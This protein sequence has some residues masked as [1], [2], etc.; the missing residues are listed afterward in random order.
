MN[1][2]PTSE[3]IVMLRTMLGKAG[4][5]HY[6]RIKLAQEIISD[7]EWL[8]T[9][10]NGDQI[11]A[12]EAL[13]KNYFGDLC[14]AISFWRLLRIIEE[15]PN[16]KDWKEHKFNLTKMSAII[17]ARNEK[18][19][20]FRWSITQKEAKELESDKNRFK[21]LYEMAKA[22]LESANKKIADLENT[23]LLLTKEKA[24]LTKEIAELQE[25]VEEAQQKTA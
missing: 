7:K 23:V 16:I 10:F 13:E 2:T 21:R 20:G 25:I 6:S 17:D 18:K 11:L 1:S 19:Q 22:D 8:V 9:N 4:E 15:F 24:R 5:M 14:G 12:G 3:K